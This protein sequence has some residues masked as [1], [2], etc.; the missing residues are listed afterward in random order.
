MI[1]NQTI[2]DL[3]RKL[4][5]DLVGFAKAEQLLNETEKLSRWIELGYQSKMTYMEQN[6]DKRKDVSLILENAV[7]VISLGMNYYMHGSYTG[8][9]GYGKVS[10]YAWGKDYHFV[11]W[12][13]FSEMISEL[14]SI[15][16]EF[17][18]KSYVDTGPVMDKV[19][20][21]RAGLGWMGKHTNV[22]NRDIGSW[23]FIANIITNRKFESKGI[24]SS[25]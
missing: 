2:L 9:E 19:W 21:V 13:K 23:F 14:Q 4:G 17:E 10:R 11:I 1:T 6:H 22:I 16:P 18:A 5:F 25:V 8:R 7:S 15:D 24:F 20:A 12:E 3:A